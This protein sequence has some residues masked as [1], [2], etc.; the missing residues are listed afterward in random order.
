MGLVM[1]NYAYSYQLNQIL[2]M[3]T[4]ANEIMQGIAGSL[5]VILTVPF[6]ALV[7]AVL[8]A[9]RRKVKITQ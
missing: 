3:Y 4:L 1:I 6:V 8:L 9:E 5:G 7:T 2:N